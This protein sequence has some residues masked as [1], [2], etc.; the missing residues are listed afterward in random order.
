MKTGLGLTKNSRSSVWRNVR[1]VV[2]D[3]PIQLIAQ[4]RTSG[5]TAL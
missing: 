2:G 4:S 3:Y 1:L 5:Q